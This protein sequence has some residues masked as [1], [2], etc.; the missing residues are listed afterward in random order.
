MG[1]CEVWS[2]CVMSWPICEE[3]PHV[4]SNPYSVWKPSGHCGVTSFS[5]QTGV[6]IRKEKTRDGAA[7]GECSEA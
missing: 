7:R 5:C 6:R 3:L 4:L 2:W 1:G